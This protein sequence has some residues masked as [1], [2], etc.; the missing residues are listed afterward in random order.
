MNAKSLELE[1][2]LYS[3]TEWIEEPDG[4]VADH[5]ISLGFQCPEDF[6]KIRVYDFL[7][8]DMVDNN[9]AEEMIVYLSDFL[10][11][12][13]EQYSDVVFEGGTTKSVMNWL[14]EHPD[15]SE[16]FLRDLICAEELCLEDM[17]YVFDC[18]SMSFY[19]SKEYNSR[20]YRYGHISE[21]EYPFCG[22]GC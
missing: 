18:I 8:L 10:Y 17:L 15:L 19:H 1:R 7:N 20:K 6:M 22:Y 12:D 14:T 13:R 16:V 21:I 11:P 3:K 4:Y 2:K 9:R 5:F